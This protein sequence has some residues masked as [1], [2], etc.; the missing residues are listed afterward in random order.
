MHISLQIFGTPRRGGLLLRM[1]LLSC[2]A[3]PHHAVAQGIERNPAPVLRPDPAKPAPPLDVDRND[4]PTP[5]GVTLTG[6][7]LVKGDA[8]PETGGPG[9]TLKGLGDAPWLADRLRH[10]IGTP[11]SRREISAIK[12][13]IAGAYRDRGRPFVHVSA[14]E[15]DISAGHLTLR[16]EPFQL[17]QTR[18]SGRGAADAKHV[19]AAIRQQPGAAIDAQTMSD[20]LDWLNRYPF[21]RVEAVFEPGRDYATTDVTYVVTSERPWA[22]GG[23]YANTGSPNTGIA[24]Y[25]LYALAGI[26]GLRDAYG[27]YQLTTSGQ[28]LAG[29]GADPGGSRRYVSH[30]G[31]IWMAIA[32]RTS[33]EA[34]I[35]DIR[36]NQP[37]DAFDA[38]QH[39]REYGL[40]LRTSLE[41]VAAGVR[42]EIYAGLDWKEQ[43]SRLLFGT[44]L[45]R[46]QSRFHVGQVTAGYALQSVD[47]M[48]STTLDVA[49]HVSPGGIDR[50]ST[51]AAYDAASLHQFGAA[52]YAYVSG[53]V[54]RRTRFH[55][56]SLVHQLN[57]QFAGVALPQ[58]E[59]LGLGGRNQVRA[60]T[61][62]DGAFDRGVVLRNEMR[63]DP[64]RI[65]Q[66]ARPS[67]IEPWLY[68]DGG[69]AGRLRGGASGPVAAGGGGVDWGLGRHL[70]VSGDVGVAMR[71]LGNT[72]AGDVRANIRATVNF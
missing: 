55:G 19:A 68:F 15:Q 49:V 58:T 46:P 51:A 67:T 37:F 57:W 72:K 23:G 11:L 35:G 61:L 6:L 31:R 26:P 38:R 28:R 40:T 18:V 63:L 20:D 34:N 17:G 48:G 32:P 8:A 25:F 45:V 30:A 66:G 4:D 12:A 13:A 52:R 42:G 22:I 65:T 69:Y 39:T 47:A 43:T 64:V 10:F 5:L 33:L 24:R 14:P 1:A 71:T 9:V 3:L 56:F 60:Y 59:L 50:Y 7:T 54:S 53:L 41:N 21:R 36:S 70:F 27:S 16:V 2:A 62:D 29:L 44:M